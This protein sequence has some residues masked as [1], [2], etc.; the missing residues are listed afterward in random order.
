[1]RTFTR[2]E[3]MWAGSALAGLGASLFV[4]GGRTLSTGKANAGG[5][6]FAESSC[7]SKIRRARRFLLLMQAA[8]G[9]R[10]VWLRL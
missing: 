2:R 9:P 10:A 8:Q 5:I 6:D 1:M 3:F 4:P 7:S